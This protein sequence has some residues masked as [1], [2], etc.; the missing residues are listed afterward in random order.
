MPSMDPVKLATWWEANP[1]Q[2]P[3]RPARVTRQAL[4]A[5]DKRFFQAACMSGNQIARKGGA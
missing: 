1:T 3:V 4:D 5:A 2:A